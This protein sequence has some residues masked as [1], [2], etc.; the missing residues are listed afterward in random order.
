MNKRRDSEGREGRRDRARSRWRKSQVTSRQKDL[1]V[2]ECLP[3]MPGG[4]IGG[5]S[6][7][8]RNRGMKFHKTPK[9][10]Q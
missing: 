8:A 9:N 4:M 3:D 2:G 1:L 7:S 6:I 5:T 10:E